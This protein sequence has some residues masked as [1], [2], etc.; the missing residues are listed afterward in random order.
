MKIELVK[1]LLPEELCKIKQLVGEAFVTNELFHNW[2]TLEERHDDVIKYMDYYVEYVYQSKALYST[3]DKT[4][5]IG[6]MDSKNA[7]AGPLLKMLLKMFRGF[8]FSKIKSLLSFIKQIE[9]GNAKYAKSHHLDIL[10]VCVD[11]G[12]QGKGIATS[13]VNFAK[14]MSD[15]KKIPLLFDT[16]MQSYAQMY[17]HLGCKLYNSITASNGVTRYNL[18]YNG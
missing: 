8:K 2:G 3:E 13:L 11:K 1:N 9:N 16:D 4:G 12:H 7:P 10:M 14:Q 18:V 5:Y 17:E 6:L 15:E